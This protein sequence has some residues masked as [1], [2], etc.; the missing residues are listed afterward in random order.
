VA[1]QE[2]NT[3]R[4][5]S[6]ADYRRWSG[7]ATLLIAATPASA[8]SVSFNHREIAELRPEELH[9]Q[10]RILVVQRL[11]CEAGLAGTARAG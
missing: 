2:R 10:L 11:Q 4:T 5:L 7:G 8:A 3:C 1:Y 6:Q 9:H